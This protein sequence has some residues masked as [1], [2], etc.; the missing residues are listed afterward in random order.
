MAAVLVIDPD[1]QG[2][3]VELD[4]GAVFPD[5][6]QQLISSP[7]GLGDDGDRLCNSL[8]ICPKQCRPL[9]D[10]ALVRGNG[11][12]DRVGIAEGENA[13]HDFSKDVV[14]TG[15]RRR[16]PDCRYHSAMNAGHH[17]LPKDLH[18]C[19]KALLQRPSDSHKYVFGRVV[20]IGGSRSMAGAPALA[21]MAA[22]RAGAGVVEIAVPE[23]IATTVAGF[24]PCL[25]V[26]PLAED[27]QGVFAAE[28]LPGLQH[29]AQRADVLVLGPGMGRAPHLAE[30]VLAIWQT[31]P[32]TLLVDADGLFALASLPADALAQPPGPRILTPHAGEMR[33]LSGS[34]LAD[35]SA[36]ERAAQDFAIARHAVL[37]L[38]GPQTLITDG[39]GRHHNGTGN[40]GM[41]SA[42]SG[43]VLSGVIAALSAQQLPP[44]VAARFG[45]WLHGL[46][47]DFAADAMS[48]PAVTATDV[49][50]HLPAA[51]K[52]VAGDLPA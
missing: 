12:A 35:R 1:Q 46:A 39:I 36:L 42:G 51:W 18:A 49:L 21:G 32:R 23:S 47:G 10:P 16:Q 13:V 37:V 3:Q 14:G 33:R 17:P 40:P 22:L 25:I 9:F 44:L 31:F 15:I 6:L 26:Q 28:S 48:T 24:N 20:V 41:A 11:L 27:A 43:D 38:K 34:G 19:A 7:T 50:D 29:L 30:T 8:A 5:T 2:D 45:V 52:A 4:Q